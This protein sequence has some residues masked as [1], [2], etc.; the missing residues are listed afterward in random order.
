MASQTSAS[1]SGQG[2]PHSRTASAAQR[3]RSR[4]RMSA[5]ALRMR[6]RSAAGASHR[7][8][9]RRSTASTSRRRRGGGRRDHAV[10]LARVDRDDRVAADAVS[11]SSASSDAIASSS[12]ART[13]ARRSSSTGSL[14]NGVRPGGRPR[15]CPATGRAGRSRWRCSPAAGARGTPCRPRDRRPGS[16]RGRGSPGGHRLLQRVAEAAQHLQLEVGV[17]AAGEAVVGDRVGDGAQVVRADGQP[18]RPARVEQ[19]ARELLEVEVAVGLDLEDGDGPAVLLGLDELVVPVGALD[20]A[21][22]ERAGRAGRARP[23][24]GSGRPCRDCRAG[25][26]GGRRRRTGRRRT[27]PRR[28]GRGSAR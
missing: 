23:S 4:R 5:A 10:A 1:A 25:R 11:G 15:R 28:A 9:A 7:R 18:H 16:R 14:R 17:L 2:L 8:A 13:G 24:R 12:D 6:A 26:P 3:R 21:D 19:P 20:E 27:P 22:G